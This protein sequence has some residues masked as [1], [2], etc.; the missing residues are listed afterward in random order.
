M[1]ALIVMHCE[2]EG[3][4]SLGDW[5]RSQGVELAYARI[6]AGEPLPP[7]AGLDAVISLGGPMNVYEEDRYPF[8]RAET[9][10]LRTAILEG[11]PVLGICL[12]AQMIAKALGSAVGKSPRPEVGFMPVELTA[13]GRR[14]PLFSGMASSQTVL[15]WHAD[16]F[17]LPPGGRLLA[18]SPD[19]PRQAF[20]YRNALGLQ[21]HLEINERLLRDWFHD[22][23]D[24]ARILAEFARLEPEIRRERTKL[25]ENFL[26]LMT[27]GK[28]DRGR[29][30]VRTGGV[31][32]EEALMNPAVVAL[33]FRPEIVVLGC[34]RSVDEGL[35]PLTA[36]RSAAGLKLRLEILPCSSKFE[37]SHLFKT[38]TE[39]AD[40]VLVLACPESAC[41]RLVG[42]TLANKR[43]ER[44][45]ALL[46]SAGLPPERLKLERGPSLGL[47]AI[48]ALARALAEEVR[49]QGPNPIKGVKRT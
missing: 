12:G 30:E 5:L 41:L 17:A 40:G 22:R 20:R 10:F 4:G 21:F 34:R 42:S 3:P 14:D 43:I 18:T 44:G 26:R 6:Y 35:D 2:T 46:A 25:Y 39:G 7:S 23:L 27:N 45:R 8:L 33:G 13:E 28:H 32:E 1:K 37:L 24:S 36:P 38:L 9:D 47:A 16:M 11:M 19:C 29:S 49:P 15:Q 48:I 31:I